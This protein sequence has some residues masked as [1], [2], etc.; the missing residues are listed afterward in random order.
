MH[1][2]TGVLLFPSSLEL[3]IT[4]A[5]RPDVQVS[6]VFQLPVADSTGRLLKRPRSRWN[7]NHLWTT[8]FTNLL[9]A[10]NEVLKGPSHRAV[11]GLVVV[12]APGSVLCRLWCRSTTETATPWTTRRSHRLRALLCNMRT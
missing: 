5:Q 4:A 1:E 12:I 11:E 8:L 3:Y 7:T 9:K 2:L 6:D 10:L